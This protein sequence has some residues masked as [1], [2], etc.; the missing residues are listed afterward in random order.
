MSGEINLIKIG[1][2][3]ENILSGLADLI[4]Q[5]FEANLL[6]QCNLPIP[7]FAYDR[8]RDQ[9]QIN[10]VIQHLTQSLTTTGQRLLALCDLDLFAPGLNFIF[11]QA[12][13]ARRLAVV[14]SLRLKESFYGR[15]ENLL[16]TRQ[17][18]HKEIVHELG[19]VYGLNH[20]PDPECVMYFSN[21]LSD[22][23]Y[24]KDNF[25]SSCFKRLKLI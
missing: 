10:G 12:D 25:C 9:Y 1:I 3:N 18:F 22:T 6:P 8:G 21:Q 5:R 15:G 4:R 24:K 7:F 14:S 16:L 17:R 20:C 13:L 11:G 19:H 2:L 23:D